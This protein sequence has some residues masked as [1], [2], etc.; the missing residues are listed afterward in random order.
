M[1]QFY[2]PLGR[3][4]RWVGE[5]PWRRAWQ[6]TPLTEGL[7]NNKRQVTTGGGGR[8]QHPVGRGQRRWLKYLTR[9]RTAPKNKRVMDPKCQ[10]VSRLRWA[11][12][13]KRL[14]RLQQKI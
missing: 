6:A 2:L 8:Y 14:G 4:Q 3:A 1:E 11:D 13:E 5:M 7:N 12:L 10:I 9:H